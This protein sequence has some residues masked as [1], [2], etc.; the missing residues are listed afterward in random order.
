[1]AKIVQKT[2]N[3]PAAGSGPQLPERI[4]VRLN[5]LFLSRATEQAALNAAMLV[6]RAG[7]RKGGVYRKTLRAFATESLIGYLANGFFSAVISAQDGADA[8]ER[9]PQEEEQDVQ[10]PRSPTPM[11]PPPPPAPPTPPRVVGS[12]QGWERQFPDMRMQLLLGSI[13][14]AFELAQGTDGAAVSLLAGGTHRSIRTLR[15][16]AKRP[17]HY[18]V[19]VAHP[20]WKDL[21]FKTWSHVVT[22]A[23]TLKDALGQD[24]GVIAQLLRQKKTFEKRNVTCTFATLEHN[25][26]RCFHT[27]LDGRVRTL[28][29]R[30]SCVAAALGAMLD[31]PLHHVF[32]GVVRRT[33]AAMIAIAAI[34]TGAR[35]RAFAVDTKDRSN[36]DASVSTTARWLDH[37]SFIRHDDVFLL[38]TGITSGPV[39]QGVCFHDNHRASTTTLC[40]HGATR[41]VRTISTQ[42]DLKE[43]SFYFD[44]G[45]GAQPAVERRDAVQKRIDD[46]LK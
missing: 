33:H 41:S 3:V 31:P 2:R 23:C 7:K 15:F 11:P 1:V 21:P 13:D 30:G 43:R 10:P 37:R 25:S 40:L 39:V 26:S 18:F 22:S 44:Q 42:H 17:R 28:S 14:G 9:E 8:K 16:R 20:T 5:G 6:G 19:V 46:L 12:L 34:T 27:L 4:A 38:I 45:N 29:H 32:A 36:K 24:D 35:F